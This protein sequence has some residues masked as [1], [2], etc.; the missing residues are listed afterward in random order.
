[1]RDRDRQPLSG[2]RLRP[3]FLLCLVR[4]V[5]LAGQQSYAVLWAGRNSSVCPCPLP[6]LLHLICLWLC[7]LSLLSLYATL[8]G[9]IISQTK[10]GSRSRP[11]SNR[12]KSRNYLRAL[13]RMACRARN[14]ADASANCIAAIE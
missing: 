6:A 2:V 11:L 5:T 1:F 10:K 13:L 7:S 4:V 3:A 8:S 12:T 9:T 14:C